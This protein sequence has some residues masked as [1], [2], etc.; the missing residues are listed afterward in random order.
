MPAWKII[1]V[2]D[3][4]FLEAAKD[5]EGDVLKILWCPFCFCGCIKREELTYQCINCKR[6]FSE[7]D[8]V[9]YYSYLRNGKKCKKE[10]LMPQYEE[11]DNYID[12]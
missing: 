12:I 3:N 10:Y 1:P 11:P 2:K 6:I 7:K 9:W 4:L 5:R 8:G